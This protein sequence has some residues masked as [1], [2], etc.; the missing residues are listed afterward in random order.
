MLVAVE[1]T[2][3]PPKRILVNW[4]EQI[5]ARDLLNQLTRLGH[6]PVGSA[7]NGH[8]AIKMAANS[9]RSNIDG[10]S[11]RR[12]DE[13]SRG[14]DE[15]CGEPAGA[16]CLHYSLPWHIH[17]PHLADGGAI[18]VRGQAVLQAKS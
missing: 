7:A 4:S 10:H 14:I 11:T 5:V 15:D 17:S 16:H 8:E 13:W 18:H 9:A 6:I 3:W 12:R 2:C 1:G